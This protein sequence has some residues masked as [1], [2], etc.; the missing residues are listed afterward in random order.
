MSHSERMSPVDTAWLRMDRPNNLM[1]I[2][3][4][5]TL[6]G[7]VDAKALASA[8][9]ERMLAHRRFRQRAVT[10]PTGAF[11]V[12][13]RDFDIARHV[14][15]VRL[16]GR[17]GE[18]VL[19]TY[20]AQLA[21]EP[22]DTNH[23]L[24]QMRIVEKYEG[25]LAIVSRIHHAV[26]DGIALMKVLLGLADDGEEARPAAH[27]HHH[28][29]GWLS[30][31]MAPLSGAAGL[32]LKLTQG[33]VREAL[34]LATNPMRAA[35]L[36]KTG[37][38][39]A[40]ELAWLLAMPSDSETRF[41][42]KP[43]GT[44]SVAWT[45][46][47]RLNEVKAASWALDCSINDILLACV[48]G[49]LRAYLEDKG[50]E[51]AG[52]EVRA[53]VPINLRPSGA[54]H[55]LGNRF[56]IIAVELPVGVADPLERL[57]EVRRRMRKLKNSYEPPVT[58]GMFAALGVAPKIMQDQLFDL[59][60][61]R[62]TAV[63]TNVPGPQKEIT[64]AGAPVKQVM[65]WVP[66][67]GDIGMGVSI[68][69]YAGNVQFGLITDAALTPDPE[70]IIGRFEREFDGYLYHVL[71]EAAARADERVAAEERVDEADKGDRSPDTPAE[72]SPTEEAPVMRKRKKMLRA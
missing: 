47:L 49:S 27:G 30:S 23:P 17:G 41:K 45:K 9:G 58:L 18:K 12:D 4:V 8:L 71:L 16:P 44:K 24:W 5:M 54:E 13:D 35:K 55:E 57:A 66:Q 29:E 56:G 11:W 1:M 31:L 67:S 69:S 42:G 34:S 32:G 59:L 50:D 15:R 25:G 53:L 70:A 46:P 7:P 65:F 38:G 61:S 52:V 63:M 14:Q 64:I 26:G 20:V 6:A 19:Q 62:A 28:D 72:A 33:A 21:S 2:T 43:H 36:I 3:G 48:A 39:V 60:I 10:T 51:S 68:L 37:A 22:L 40:G